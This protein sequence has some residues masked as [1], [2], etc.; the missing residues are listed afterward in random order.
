MEKIHISNPCPMTL[1]SLQNQNEL[2]HCRSC[3]KNITDCRGLNKLEVLSKIKPGDCG[4]FDSDLVATNKKTTFYRFRYF[5]LVILS[6]I[7]FQVSPIQAQ[8]IDSTKQ[9]TFIQSI[10]DAAKRSSEKEKSKKETKKRN[11]LFTRKKFRK[12]TIG[13]PDF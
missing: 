12:Q 11:R 9:H 13:C 4:I 3:D 10:K 7:G 6:W 1:H 5:G 2:L 8:S